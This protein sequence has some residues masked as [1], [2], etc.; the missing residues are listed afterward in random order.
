MMSTVSAT[1][2]SF[3][4]SS[5]GS[6]PPRS[7]VGPSVAAV[8]REH[9]SFVWRVLRR[10]GLSPEDADDA[11]QQVF[12]VLAGRTA[13]VV[14]GKERP[15]LWK[16]ALHVASRAHRS[17][18]RRPEKADADCGDEADDAP[19]PDEVV[20]QRRAR[21]LLDRLLLDMSEELRSP[22]VLFEI[23]GLTM[24]EISEA[25]DVPAGTVASRLR[26]ARQDL[27]A[28]LLRAQ[29]RGLSTGANR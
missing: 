19:G 7:D 22:L 26:R 27:E 15:F 16:T 1:T 18:R 5:C 14:P 8:V 6:S 25:L 10:F 28:R 21:A 20:D 9:Y 13:D 24:A 12:M 2:A 17:K 4:D 23:E 29:S 11:A 3:R